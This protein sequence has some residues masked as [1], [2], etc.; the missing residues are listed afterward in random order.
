MTREHSLGSGDSESAALRNHPFADLDFA[1]ARIARA[2]DHQFGSLKIQQRSL[3]T[4]EPTVFRDR[5]GDL[6]RVVRASQSNAAAHQRIF[7]A[8]RSGRD[9]VLARLTAAGWNG[10]NRT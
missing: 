8:R 5:V 10:I 1:R 3:Q 7:P 4:G 2:Q 6:Q 9:G